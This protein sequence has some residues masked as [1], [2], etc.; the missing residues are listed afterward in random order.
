MKARTAFFSGVAVCLAAS[1]RVSSAQ[2]LH[3]RSFLQ[4]RLQPVQLA[5]VN[6]LSLDGPWLAAGGAD[7]S[8]FEGHALYHFEDSGW[9]ARKPLDV[10]AFVDIDRDRYVAS[11]GEYPYAAV[12]RLVGGRWELE[13]WLRESY[14]ALHGNRMLAH[15]SDGEP[16]YWVTPWRLGPLG[17]EP[18]PEIA[19][20]APQVPYYSCC[21]PPEIWGNTAAFVAFGSTGDDT[22][23]VYA[24]ALGRWS[25]QA[26]L[27]PETLRGNPTVDAGM[28]KLWG[29]TLVATFWDGVETAAY[30]WERERGVW[31]ER[32][33]LAPGAPVWDL[34]FQRDTIALAL[35]T[36]VGKI[37]IY[38]RSLGNWTPTWRLAAST[39]HGIG[40]AVALDGRRV[41]ASTMT[42]WPPSASRIYLFRLPAP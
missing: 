12:Y 1:A 31:H 16:P 32:A 42:D 36:P 10:G 27:V 3:E 40:R 23:Q 8:G 25:K 24:R 9:V 35:G 28:I 37:Q 18:E 13:T 34:D 41:A 15:S 26:E 4:T 14:V 11:T 2:E 29:N 5:F 17:W 7:L 39:G 20:E 19:P 22:I 33:R 6:F 21:Y 38:E 30:V